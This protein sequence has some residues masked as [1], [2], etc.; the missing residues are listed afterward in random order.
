MS[1]P[2]IILTNDDGIEAKGIKQL[3]KVLHEADFADLFVIAPTTE[4]SGTGVS[5]T[6]DRPMLIQEAAWPGDTP[7]WSVDGTPADCIKMGM[8]VILKE[9]PDFIISGINAGS[10]AGRNVLHS[11]TIGAV[12]E[13]IFR[14]IPGMALSCENGEEPNF[15]V[16]EKYV[17]P[18]TRYLMNSPLPPGSF[19]N[20]NFPHAVKDKVKGFRLT[21]QGK[22]R[23]AEDPQL[24]IETD[25]GPS[26]WLGG[27]PEESSEDQDCDIALLKEGYLTAVPIHV[28]ELTD[29]K[30]LS[31][32]KEAFEKHFS[33]MS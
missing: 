4:R 20:V 32:R 8:R 2:R 6:W 33:H 25:H 10:N 14:G 22:G 19:L 29:H 3:W 11:G 7:A 16:A 9:K 1:R 23:W 24:H 12:I 26:Y 21:R 18:L 30:E 15:H 5:I 27:K 31:I 28:H 13:G 17:L